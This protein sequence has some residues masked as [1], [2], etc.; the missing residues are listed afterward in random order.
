MNFLKLFLR[1]MGLLPSVIQSVEAMFG[2]KSGE[3]KKHAVLGIVTTAINIADAVEILAI[4]NV[5]AAGIP[6]WTVPQ[7]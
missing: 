1:G 2:S 4:R 7:S 3:Q 6:G 5:T